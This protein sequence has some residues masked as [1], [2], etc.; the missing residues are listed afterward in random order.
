[1]GWGGP[2]LCLPCVYVG[3]SKDFHEHGVCT[4][5]VGGPDAEMLYLLA[6]RSTD[7]SRPAQSRSW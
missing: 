5:I 7:F 6:P 4:E 2:G 3:G 1:M